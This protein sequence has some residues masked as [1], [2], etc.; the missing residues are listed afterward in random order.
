MGYYNIENDQSP[1]WDSNICQIN[2]IIAIFAGTVDFCYNCFFCLYVLYT[3]RNSLKRKTLPPFLIH[4]IGLL[5]PFSIT[6]FAYV[7]NSTGLTLFGTCS[8]GVNTG[9]PLMGML[10]VCF[11]FFISGITI[12]YYRK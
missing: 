1:L 10:I 7:N 6:L 2:A 11:Y 8:Y 12:F 9:F 4:S 5:I 3:I